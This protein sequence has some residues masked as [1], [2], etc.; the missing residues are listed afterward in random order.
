MSCLCNPYLRLSKNNCFSNAWINLARRKASQH[1]PIIKV[2]TGHQT[3]LPQMCNKH[4]KVAKD[5]TIYNR[6]TL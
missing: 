6:L 2:S 4:T 1:N 3:I 5:K